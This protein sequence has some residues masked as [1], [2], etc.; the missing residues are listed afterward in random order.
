MNYRALG[1]FGVFAAL[2]LT[3]SLARAQE[4]DEEE[5]EDGQAE[6]AKPAEGEAKAEVK[7]DATAKAPLSVPPTAA[8]AEPAEGAEASV[9]AYEALRPPVYGKRGDWFIQPYGYARFDAIVD[10]TQSFDDGL[11]PW[12]IQRAGTYRGSHRRAIFTARDSRFGI[13]VG[14]PEFHGLKTSGGIELDFYGLQVSDAKKHDQV[15][16]GPLRL[17]LA[18]VKLET[19]VVDILAGQYQEVF[20]WSSYFYPA[21]VSYLGVPG[22][23]YHRNAGRVVNEILVAGA[24]A[25]A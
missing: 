17:R 12:L 1:S 25:T 7:A 6:S 21:T 20:G 22:E 2:L 3:G 13:F 4:D 14:A 23:L 16:M 10:S 5:A 24:T 11:Q 18:Y 15:V 9:E 8:A 19:S